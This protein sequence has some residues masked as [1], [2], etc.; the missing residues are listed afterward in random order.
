MYTRR[1]FGKFALASVPASLLA[2]KKIN[3]TIGGVM[4]G[5]QSYSFREKPLDGVLQAMVEIGLGECELFSPHIEPKGVSR[6]DLRKWRLT[7][8]LDE[9]KAIR[10]RFDDAGINLYAF[11]LSF[12]DSFTDEEIDR[13]FVMAKALGVPVI[14]ASATV[15]SAKRVAPFADKHNMIVAFHGH[16]DIKDPNQFAKPEAFAQALAMSKK[17]AINLDIGHFVAANY[18]PVEYI[19]ANHQHILVLHAAVCRTGVDH[20]GCATPKSAASG[21]RSSTCYSLSVNCPPRPSGI[22]A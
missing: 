5:A 15:S 8:P 4:I 20:D 19:R 10:K 9:I 18:D 14:T 17:F 3:S 7:V 2:Q 12:N 11:N 1:D 6:E 22:H 16:S 21:F 13:G